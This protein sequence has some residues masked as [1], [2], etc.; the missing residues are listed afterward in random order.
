MEQVRQVRLDLVPLITATFSLDQITDAYNLFGERSDGV[1][2]V[3][4]KP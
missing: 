1:I 2:K 4:I 3:A